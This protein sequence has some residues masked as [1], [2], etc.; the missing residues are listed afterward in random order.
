MKD[1]KNIRKERINPW[2]VK[3]EE[4]LI[5]LVREGHSNGQIA[6]ILNRTRPSVNRKRNVLV[7]SGRLERGRVLHKRSA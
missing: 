1:A 7:E 3:E 6:I 5:K 4:A 2:S